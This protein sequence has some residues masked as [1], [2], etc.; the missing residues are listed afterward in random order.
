MKSI[1]GLIFLF[2]FTL[3]HANADEKELGDSLRKALESS[4]NQI[5]QEKIET[6]LTRWTNNINSNNTDKKEFKREDILYFWHS[7]KPVIKK[8]IIKE[9]GQLSQSDED[10]Y[11]KDVERWLQEDN[12]RFQNNIQILEIEKGLYFIKCLLF[13]GAYQGINC[14]FLWDGKELDIV[15]FPGLSEES[16]FSQNLLF[17]SAFFSTNWQYQKPYFEIH[18]RDRGHCYC[19]GITYRYL[20]QDKKLSLLTVIETSGNKEIFEDPDKVN[21][22]LKYYRKILYNSPFLVEDAKKKPLTPD[23][24]RASSAFPNN[25]YLS[26]TNRLGAMPF[27]NIDWKTKIIEFITKIALFLL[28]ILFIFS[29]LF[30][31]LWLKNI[32]S[33]ELKDILQRIGYTISIASLIL[34]FINHLLFI[35]YHLLS[36]G[37]DFERLLSNYVDVFFFNK[38]YYRTSLWGF[39]SKF[40]FWLSSLIFIVGML[41]LFFHKKVLRAVDWI[42]NG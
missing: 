11:F 19:C 28:W 35:L 10:F 15:E 2:I 21:D 4:V 8:Q 42:R 37:I 40:L 17:P 33:K 13:S 32:I 39:F 38:Q 41:L 29:P 18:A 12:H 36:F 24:I 27:E 9:K 5:R 16:R 26:D 1:L 20:F 22:C 23:S 31:F 7:I 3:S 25:S 14:S 34:F 6:I 30:I